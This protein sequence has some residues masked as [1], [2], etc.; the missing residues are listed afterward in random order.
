ML[1]SIGE[2]RLFA[3]SFAPQGWLFCDGSTLSMY[4]HM[5]LYTVLQYKFGSD[6]YTN[7]QLPNL[8]PAQEDDGGKAPIRYIIC[9]QGMFP[10]RPG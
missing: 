4:Q 2:I 9:V 1:G 8:A 10:L 5:A 6:D 7:F 3:G